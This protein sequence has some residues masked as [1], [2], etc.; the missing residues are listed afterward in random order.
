MT[1]V[2]CRGIPPVAVVFDM[3]SVAGVRVNPQT[4]DKEQ[5]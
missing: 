5:A 2:L 4:E 3:E 1:A